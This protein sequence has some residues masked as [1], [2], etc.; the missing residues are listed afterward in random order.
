MCPQGCGVGSASRE[1]GGLRDDQPVERWRRGATHVKACE[2]GMDCCCA[3]GI[4]GLC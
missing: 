2:R 3:D 1:A 4:G